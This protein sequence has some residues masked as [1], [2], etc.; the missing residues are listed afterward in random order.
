MSSVTDTPTTLADERTAFTDGLRALADWL[1][2]HP[3]VDTPYPRLTIHSRRYAAGSGIAEAAA[4]ARAMGTCEKGA[5]ETLNHFTLTKQFGP[6]ALRWTAGRAAVCEK[7]SVTKTVDEW[8]CPT[9]L[10]EVAEADGA[11]TA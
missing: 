9:L 5:D 4:V 7:R 8:V 11:V 6:I 3:D 10:A 2:A 1:D